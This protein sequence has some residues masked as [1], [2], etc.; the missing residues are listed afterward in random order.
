MNTLP[1]EIVDTQVH[2]NAFPLDV[3]LTTMD[4]VGVDA[5]IIDE[6]AGFDHA[7]RVLPGYELPG[8]ALRSTAPYSE[9]A[10]AAHPD[11]FSFITRADPDD[12]EL[13]EVIGGL[14][15]RP[16][17]LGLRLIPFV[18][19]H[20]FQLPEHPELLE[21]THDA[22]RRFAA[23]VRSERYSRYFALA[24]EHGVPVFLQING[25]CLPGDFSLAREIAG[26]YPDLTIIIDHTG[27]ELPVSWEQPRPD[28]FAQLPELLEL[29]TFNNIAL[30]WAHAPLLSE[31]PY[32]FRDVRDVFHRVVERFGVER[33]MWGSDWTVDTSHVS[34]LES[35]AT[36]LD[37]DAFTLEEKAAL[38]G[39][40]VRSVLRWTK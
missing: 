12:P 40:T 15:K 37:D 4:A 6:F 34:W 26:R 2:L 29:A 8:G 25:Y 14:R 33:V 21:V 20:P 38:L 23:D 28:R 36:V 10:V 24:E 32:P 18:P 1:F 31:E 11:R 17:L 35:L 16:G 7:E 27:L 5:V 22:G 30:K 3:A 13:D 19:I 9:A 39:G